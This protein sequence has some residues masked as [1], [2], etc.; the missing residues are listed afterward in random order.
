MS[1]GWQY[2]YVPDDDTKRELFKELESKGYIREGGYS[3][4]CVGYISIKEEPCKRYYYS[5]YYN[6]QMFI[7]KGAT[8]YQFC[9]GLYRIGGEL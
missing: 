5:G 1:N 6:D 7:N 2:F 9:R 4:S 8:P 3:K